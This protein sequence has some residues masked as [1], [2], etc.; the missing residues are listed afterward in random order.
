MQWMKRYFD[1][2]SNG[3]PYNAVQ[4]RQEAMQ[5]RTKGSKIAGVSGLPQSVPQDVQSLPVAA[6]KAPAATATAAAPAKHVKS[7]VAATAAGGEMQGKLKELQ[8]QVTDQKVTI[9]N[10]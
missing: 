6:A 2:H 1:T 8:A 3:L 7:S 5:A 4:R 10:L 9:D